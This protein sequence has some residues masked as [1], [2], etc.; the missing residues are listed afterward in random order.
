MRWRREGKAKISAREGRCAI[1]PHQEILVREAPTTW[2]DRETEKEARRG[3]KKERENDVKRKERKRHDT[4]PLRR[5]F[6]SDRLYILH[7]VSRGPIFANLSITSIVAFYTTHARRKKRQVA[8]D[9]ANH[10]WRKRNR[11]HLRLCP[12][13]HKSRQTALVR[14]TK[15]RYISTEKIFL[16][17]DID[18]Y[19]Y[20]YADTS[21]PVSQTGS[22]RQ[23]SA[24][25][26]IRIDAIQFAI[27]FK[28]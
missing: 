24:L 13:A 21:S 28:I 26:V 8:A 18:V 20:V 7:D 17:R 23:A 19:T 2:T 25:S 1:V 6:S 4:Q 10:R 5:F 12:T 14:I 11:M 16:S 9:A 3:T 27:E 22:S 15:P